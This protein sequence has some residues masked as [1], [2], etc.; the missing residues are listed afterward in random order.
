MTME[1]RGFIQETG[2]IEFGGFSQGSLGLPPFSY[3]DFQ[4]AAPL[5]Q[6]FS[7]RFFS[8]KVSIGRQNP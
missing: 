4:G 3:Q 8:R 5:S 2:N 1:K 6:S 7:R